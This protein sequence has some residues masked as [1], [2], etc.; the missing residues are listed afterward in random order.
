M[1]LASK[2]YYALQ[3]T[4]PS[5]YRCVCVCVCVFSHSVVSG[6]FQPHGQPPA[7][8]SAHG[9]FRQEPWSES[10]FLSPGD[11]PNPGTEVASLESP[12]PQWILPLCHLGSPS[13]HITTVFYL[14]HE[15][16]V[17]APPPLEADHLLLQRKESEGQR[18]D[19]HPL[20]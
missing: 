3:S 16:T 10:P 12:P 19:S 14:L 20:S 18:D 7:G 5:S 1:V 17:Y 6:S 15:F 2:N 4:D 13:T 8:P 9:I 11:L